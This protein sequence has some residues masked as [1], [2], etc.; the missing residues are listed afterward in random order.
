MR[1]LITAAVVVFPIKQLMLT[2]IEKCLTP[3][4]KPLTK[5]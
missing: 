5:V 2:I 3:P 1:A 4:I